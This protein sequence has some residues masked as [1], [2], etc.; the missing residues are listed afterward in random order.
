MRFYKNASSY[1]RGGAGVKF[2]KANEIRINTIIINVLR[3][4]LV[5][6]SAVPIPDWKIGIS[7]VKDSIL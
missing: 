3:K 4:K 1:L 2:P 5:S 7:L 6:V